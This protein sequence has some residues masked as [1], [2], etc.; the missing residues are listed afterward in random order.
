MAPEPKETAATTAADRGLPCIIHS[1]A[2]TWHDGCVA[3]LLPDGAIVALAA[4]RVGDRYKH[5]WNSRLAYDH[6]RGQ[7]GRGRCFGGAWDRF[8]DSAQGLAAG[9]H[10]LYHA[11]TAF[12]GS[13][14]RE[15]AI[16]IVDGQGPE[17]E[18]IATT[19]VW[20]GCGTDIALVE[21][22]HTAH[23][24]FAP[25]SLGHF[26]TAIGAMAGMT[27]L[28]QEGKTMA[29]A[30]YGRPSRFLDFIR[31]FAGSNRDGTYHVDPQFTLAMLGNTLGP[32]LLGWSPQPAGIQTI[33]DEFQSLRSPGSQDEP[34]PN[35]D[36]MD[37]AY[38]GQVVLE[39]IMVELAR[40]VQRLTNSRLLCLGGGVALNCVANEKLRRQGPFTDVFVGPAPGDDGQA[41]GKLLLEIKQLHLP[42]DTKME[43]AYF[44]PRYTQRQVDEAFAAA[45]SSLEC[46]P[47]EKVL[48][49]EEV[50]T[51]LAA[52]QVIGWF[53]GSSELGPRALGHRSI[54]AD[55]RDPAMR[56]YINAEVKHR[57]WYRPLAPM[58]LEDRAQEFFVT[59]RPSPFMSFAVDVRPERISSLPA[60]THIDGTARLQTVS[61]STCPSCYELL[62]RFDARTGIP[63][64]INTSFNRRGEPIVETPHD[65][66]VAFT[67]MKLD[68]LV[69]EGNLVTRR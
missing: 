57:E 17:G 5:S 59:D 39:E 22:Q 30:A 20:R 48:L 63:V 64:L 24:R 9:H 10:H 52:G 3:M 49:W 56:Q 36:D 28:W 46:R 65:A 32:R 60:V 25:E 6:L 41:I 35:Q 33:W 16:L 4:E 14:F 12:F 61:R 69:V 21:L 40:R 54:L 18:Q 67:D 8:V 58:V 23:G 29:L 26:Y 7:T 68:A 53:E 50:T 45:P 42:L 38:A 51:R 44:G 34:R 19:S 66:L 13:G 43:G 2:T 27:D 37:I 55:S 62:S 1:H 31:H 47:I 11:A 15:S